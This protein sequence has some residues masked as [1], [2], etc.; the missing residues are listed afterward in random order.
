[1]SKGTNCRDA[2]KNWEAKTGQIAQEA[3]E[4]TLTCQ[5]PY[6]EKMDDSLN[7]LVSCEKLSLSTNSIERMIAL[8]KLKNIRILSIGRNNIKKIAGLDDIGQTL[9]QL[10]I[11]YNQIDK[12]DGLSNCAKLHTLFATNNKIKN[13]DEIAK[14]SQ[15]PELKSVL[16]GA[17]SIYSDRIW[18]ENAPM[19]VKRVPQL[20][21]IESRMISAGIRKQAEQLEEEE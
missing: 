2:I 11:S 18:E 12:L 17:N 16:L 14:L 10:W 3:R 15:L 4:V 19:V 21:M 13:W 6:I 8:P 9:E 5:I 7:S 1:M 20:E